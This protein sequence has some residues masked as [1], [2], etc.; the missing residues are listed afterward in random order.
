VAGHADA[1]SNDRQALID[2]WP[3]ES[4]P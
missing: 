1:L 2:A 4:P 3:V